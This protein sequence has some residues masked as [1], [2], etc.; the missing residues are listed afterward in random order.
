MKKI[1][2]VI[3][4]AALVISCSPTLKVK[5]LDLKS[6]KLPTETILTNSEILVKKD[7]D[8]TEYKQF[9]FVKKSGLNM[10][11][12]ENYILGTLKNVGG[13]DKYYTQ[14]E[15][16]QYVIQNGLT[17]KV[18][19]ISDNIGLMNLSKNVGKFLICESNVEYKGGYDFTFEYKVINPTNAEV[20]LHIKHNAF[21]WG[22]LDRP[23]FNPVFN[24]Y[25][26]WTKANKKKI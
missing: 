26:D 24:E 16:E 3:T 2:F 5:D 14:S 25:I 13:F 9:L 1:L 15:L 10:E 21:N 7:I 12:Y 23:L 18:T 17:D 8:L 22:G 6:G 4:L 19:S 20:L 11:K